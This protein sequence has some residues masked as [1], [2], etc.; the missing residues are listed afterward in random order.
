M[1][2]ALISENWSK[3]ILILIDNL[4]LF[5][6]GKNHNATISIGNLNKEVCCQVNGLYFGAYRL[7]FRLINVIK[8]IRSVESVMDRTALHTLFFALNLIWFKIFAI[9]CCMFFQLANRPVD[10]KES[11]TDLL[12]IHLTSSSRADMAGT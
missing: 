8:S 10:G 7:F 4:I 3:T 6:A 1:W 2:K 5:Y 12:F 11:L 9:F